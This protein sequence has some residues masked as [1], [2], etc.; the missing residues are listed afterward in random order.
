MISTDRSRQSPERADPQK[1]SNT[2]PQERTEQSVSMTSPSSTDSRATL[3]F[4]RP[5]RVE[6]RYFAV[7]RE[8]AACSTETLLTSSANPEEL[9]M[10]LSTRHPLK[11]SASLVKVS[12]NSSFVPWTHPLK[13]GDVV[14]FIP[15]VA[16]G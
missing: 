5:K 15:P 16:G 7:L 9:Y 12:V 4:P 6:V 1:L 13:D 10:E 2:A 8:R 14:V 3:P 11:L